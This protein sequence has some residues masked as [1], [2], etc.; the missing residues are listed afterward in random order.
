MAQPGSLNH[1]QL[2]QIRK[3]LSVA[4]GVVFA[5]QTLADQSLQL[6][7]VDRVEKNATVSNITRS[8]GFGVEGI[9]TVNGHPVCIR[10][11]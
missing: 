9:Q 4:R 5:V 2:P 6:M 11:V 1:I 7:V 3:C 10:L 8:T